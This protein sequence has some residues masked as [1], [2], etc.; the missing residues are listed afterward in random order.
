MHAHATIWEDQEQIRPN[1]QK[2]NHSKQTVIIK[3][4]YQA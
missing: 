2:I 1:F 3:D 4:F